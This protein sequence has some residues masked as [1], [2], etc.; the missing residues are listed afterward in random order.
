MAMKEGALPNY[1]EYINVR[2]IV[3]IRHGHWTEVIILTRFYGIIDA[4][5][6]G[7]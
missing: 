1:F 2:E 5:S 3:A 7:C 4:Q 6:E